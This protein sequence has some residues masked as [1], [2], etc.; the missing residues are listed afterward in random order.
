[1]S[2]TKG[3]SDE[4]I[5]RPDEWREGRYQIDGD[6]VDRS[7]EPPPNTDQPPDVVSTPVTQKDYAQPQPAPAERRS[8]AKSER[9]EHEKS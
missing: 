2:K 6:S 7:V 4:A 3:S 8:P 9:G 1:M 5:G